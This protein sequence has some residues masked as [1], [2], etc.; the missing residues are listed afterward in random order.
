M[1]SRVTLLLV[2][3]VV[4]VGNTGCCARFRNWLHRGSRCGT[5]TVAPAMMGAPVPLGTPY[6][7]PQPAPTTAAPSAPQVIVPQ[8][9]YQCVPQCIP[10]CPPQYCNPCYDPCDPCQGSMM[11]V[12]C[13]GAT[14][15]GGYIENGQPASEIE[16]Y[17]GNTYV[18]E[19]TPAPGPGQSNYPP[20]NQS[21]EQ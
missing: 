11:G 10:M 19:S 20:K 1:K 17:E 2:L 3:A 16:T 5:T 12:P 14:W 13:D 8:N 4:T 9:N 18:P 15:F 7:A 21:E 6:T